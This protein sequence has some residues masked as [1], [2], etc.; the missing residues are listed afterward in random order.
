MR[1][2]QAAVTFVLVAVLVGLGCKMEQKTIRMRER[3]P[4]EQAKLP[5]PPKLEP[6]TV[7]ARYPDGSYSV[8]GLLGEAPRLIGQTVRLKGF[9]REVNVCDAKVDSTCTAAPH[10]YLI[11]DPAKPKRAM[12]LVGTTLSVL[13]KLQ[14]GKGEMVEGTVEQI[15]PD[16]QFVRADGMLVLPDV[17]PP[18]PPPG[19]ADAG[20]TGADGGATP[21]P[22]APEKKGP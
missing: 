19:A 18:P 15:S 16:G 10:A 7:V 14:P 22:A 13:P 6:S 12:L 21:P 8:D 5:P 11:D 2:R 17:E 20:P 3:G 9:V 4:E 1:Q